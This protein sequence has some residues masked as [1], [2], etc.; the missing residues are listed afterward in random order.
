M[1]RKDPEPSPN[2]SLVVLTFG[3]TLESP[4]AEILRNTEAWA[5]PQ[6]NDIMN[7]QHWLHLG[8]APEI[9]NLRPFPDLVDRNLN[10]AL[11]DRMHSNLWEG[12][13]G[14]TSSFYK[15]GT[16]DLFLFI[17]KQQPDT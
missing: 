12:L 3:H 6:T 2:S 16:R 1:Y 4:H 13:I 11:W 9:Q 14:L 8:T 7:R 17:K 10:K 15:G 5:T